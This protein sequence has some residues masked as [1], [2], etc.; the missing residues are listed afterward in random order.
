MSDFLGTAQGFASQ[1]L[2]SGQAGL[3][4]RGSLRLASFRGVP[5]KVE[6]HT[7]TGGRRNASHVYPLREQPATED[8]GRKQRQYKITAFVIGDDYMAQRDDLLAACEDSDQ[9]GTLVHPFLGEL[10][11]RCEEVSWR[12]SMKE[13]RVCTLSLS[14]IEAGEEPSPVQRND[15][16]GQ[17]I[18]TVRRAVRLA[19]TA[20]SIY[21][22]ARGDLVGF[23][24]GVLLGQARAYAASLGLGWLSLPGFNLSG[25][26]SA[27]DDIDASPLATP[28]QVAA[29]FAPPYI[30]L[31]EAEPIAKPPQEQGVALSS[32]T[33][34]D[35]V[36]GNLDLLL[37]EALRPMPTSPNQD[38]AIAL[39]A[40]WGFNQDCAA[41]A[42]AEAA[43][44]TEWPSADAALSARDLVLAMVWARQDAAGDA[45]QDD[46][47]GAWGALATSVTEDLTQ[48]AA[49][50]PRRGTYAVP[51]ALPSLALSQRLYGTAARA[52]ELVAQ[53][54]VRHPAFMP[55]RGPLLRP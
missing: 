4:W 5:F 1:A 48:R 9:V 18:Q 35:R 23:A 40:F 11:V 30:A 36:G 22:S 39:A 14:F 17:L 47:F 12:E 24:A 50:L 45:G 34:A 19:Q 25:L 2:A 43:A 49:A 27:F 7:A 21:A 15:T 53:G 10:Q 31:A 41:A 28:E 32:R 29:V 52:D 55:A 42:A 16:L 13:G 6:D 3:S 20:Y 38:E 26:I 54:R 44:L 37:A 46:L 51:A 33:D 8:L